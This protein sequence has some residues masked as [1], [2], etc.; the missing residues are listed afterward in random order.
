[1]RVVTDNGYE[2]GSHA[3]ALRSMLRL[4]DA[5]NAAVHGYLNGNP[6]MFLEV[7]L[8][9]GPAGYADMMILKAQSE[10]ARALCVT[11]RDEYLSGMP[12][13]NQYEHRQHSVAIMADLNAIDVMA[14]AFYSAS[15]FALAEA[16]PP[17]MASEDHAAL[18][19]LYDL[20][21]LAA[22]CRLAL[23]R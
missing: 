14:Q 22:T 4:A 12:A 11:T 19:D 8:N 15:T 9:L 1:V 6:P 10:T 21:W 16:L 2:N 23:R 13:V 17:D 20:S 7:M 18:F 5:F 3:G